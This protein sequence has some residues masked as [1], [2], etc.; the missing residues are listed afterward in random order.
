MEKKKSRSFFSD[1]FYS[2][3]KKILLSFYILSIVS[4]GTLFIIVI[5]Y[6]PWVTPPIQ[7][8]F[9][10]L[11]TIA[12]VVAGAALSVTLDLPNISHEF[13]KIKNDIALRKIDSPEVFAQR[14]VSLLCSYFTFSFFTI[15]Y[16][17]VKIIDTDCVYSD[18]DVRK[19]IHE[20]DFE[21]I[22]NKSR[23]TEDVIY[24]GTRNIND[25]K[26]H[27]YIFPIWFGDE[28]LGF[29]GILT[30]NKLLR[31]YYSFLA[32]FEDNYLDDQL[33]HVIEIKKQNI[34][35]QCYKDINT[36]SSKI[37]K[38]DYATIQEYQKD[39]LVFLVNNTNCVGGLFATI[40]DDDC[41]MFFKDNA[42]NYSQ[43][44]EY[45]RL[46]YQKNIVS[47]QPRIISPPDV[48]FEYVF[49]IPLVIE[50][51]IGIIHLF[52]STDYNFR[53]FYSI[54]IDMGNI[55]FKYDL[56]NLAHFLGIS[57]RKDALLNISR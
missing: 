14:I 18:N 45:Y 52:D 38:Q 13:D 42:F 32:D 25:R 17:F 30:V 55:K 40:Y 8:L 5:G 16:A 54:I 3:R 50:K 26:Y 12:G 47:V 49:E 33:I 29:V 28:W 48:P 51:T 43:I 27:F 53:Y 24:I 11:F 39:V 1:V 9:G 56:A 2:V 7:A 15:K 4:L 44:S 35:Q 34:Q 57:P 37:A 36:F 41:I 31:L 19:T 46:Y 21:S 20:S 10:L 23:T 6:V 22:L